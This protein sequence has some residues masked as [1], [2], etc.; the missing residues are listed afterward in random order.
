M[1][2]LDKRRRSAA[3]KYDGC[4][5]GV[6]HTRPLC[7]NSAGRDKQEM[8]HYGKDLN[9]QPPTSA[10]K[11][12]GFWMGLACE[13]ENGICAKQLAGVQSFLILSR[14]GKMPVGNMDGVT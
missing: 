6:I 14:G 12:A 11:I 9:I 5:K 4:A 1:A 2:R 3:E 7:L 13:R 8:K 10:K